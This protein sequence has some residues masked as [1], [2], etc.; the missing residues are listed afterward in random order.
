LGSGVLNAA[1]ED[2]AKERRNDQGLA[3][4]HVVGERFIDTYRAS[5]QAAGVPFVEPERQEVPLN[6]E[7][8][9]S[10]LLY[11]I[12]GYEAD[13]ASMYAAVDVIVG[14]GGAGTVAEVAVTGTPAVLIPWAQAADDHQTENVRWLADNGGA[15]FISEDLCRQELS[16][17]LNTLRQDSLYREQLGRQAYV[18]GEKNRVGAIAALI[19]NV[20]LPQVQL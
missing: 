5:L 6:P 3:I 16:N 11:Q 14:R 12:V 7:H 18:L 19:D 9:E 10:G 17:V 20:A 2:F 8:A 1:I 15:V 13:M 4:R